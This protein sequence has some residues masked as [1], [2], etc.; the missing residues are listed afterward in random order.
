[1][2]NIRNFFKIILINLGLLILVFTGLELTSRLIYPEFLGHIHSPT[3]T[4]GK[5]KEYTYFYGYPIRTISSID[6]KKKKL[7]Y[8]LVFG[9]SISE[10]YG[11]SFE[12]IWWKQLERL[13][14]IK[15]KNYNFIAVAGFGNNF[16][17]NI[18]HI[19]NILIKTEEENIAKVIYQFNFN[20]ISPIS[21][22]TLNSQ[23]KIGDSYNFS[24]EFAKWR[25]KHLNKS[26]SFRVAQFYAGKITKKTKGSCEDR[27]L[28]ALGPYTW[29]FGSKPFGDVSNEAWTKFN[30]NLKVIKL[31]LDKRNIE[32]EIVVSPILTQIDQTGNHLYYNN[33]NYDF[34]CATID[35]ISNLENASIKMNIKLYNPIR[36]I[37]EN[38]ELRLKEGNFE[39]FFS[40]LT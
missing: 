7:P 22:Y 28:H 14:R 6:V 36:Y 15:K 18:D 26:V 24:R 13:L 25:Y 39:P 2:N 12:D 29:T 19:K 17:D 8:V 11:H 16:Y 32:F 31:E 27:M 34:S 1:M 10:G 38:F 3:M 20:D 23:I 35:P 40:Q 9:D 21:R 30:K 5:N 4:M 33:L 37:K